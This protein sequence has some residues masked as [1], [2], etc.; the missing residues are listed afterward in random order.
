MLMTK[1]AGLR[2]PTLNPNYELEMAL[3]KAEILDYILSIR[4]QYD[5]APLAGRHVGGL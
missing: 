2:G 1:V 5:V 3:R 4:T